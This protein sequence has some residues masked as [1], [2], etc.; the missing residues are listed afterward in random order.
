MLRD[1]REAL[2]DEVVGRDLDLLRQAF[3][4]GDGQANGHG[5]TRRELL[6][7]DCK[8]VSADDGRVNPARYL[9]QLPE[10]GRDLAPR[11]RQPQAGVSVGSQLLLEQAQLEREGDQPLLGAVVQVALQSL[12]LL[13]SGLDDPRTRSPQLLQARPQLDVQAPVL[14]C[15]AGRRADGVEQLGLVDQRGIVDQGRHVLPLPVDHG[16]RPVAALRGQ[17][18][19]PAVEVGPASELREP[20]REAQ[21]RVAQGPRECL[22]ELGR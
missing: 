16:R 10:R 9:A 21:R 20:V 3:L 1:V 4:D 8:P 19:R 14:D 12:P 15:D 6:E 22:T 11:L 18:H 2:G 5:R 17:L 13:L 7:S